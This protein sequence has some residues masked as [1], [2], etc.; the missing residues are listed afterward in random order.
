MGDR[1]C[2]DNLNGAHFEKKFYRETFDQ[3]KKNN[4]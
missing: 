3:I 2:W 1:N 4:I